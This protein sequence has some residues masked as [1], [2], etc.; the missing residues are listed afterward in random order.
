MIHA[1][2][3]ICRILYYLHYMRLVSRGS[4]YN[5]NRIIG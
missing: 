1:A 5:V 2:G 3:V 4:L